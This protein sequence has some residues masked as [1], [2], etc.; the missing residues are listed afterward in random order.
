[1]PQ[2]S[3]RRLGELDCRIITPGGTG[4]GTSDSSVPELVLVL[5]HG[6]G[7]P[8]D[9]L[10]PVTVELFHKFPDLAERVQVVFPAAPLSLDAYGLP[11]GRAWW[12]LDM[13]KLN[14][15][16]QTGEFRDLRREAPPGLAEAHRKFRGVV[17]ELQRE[18]GLPLSRFVLGGFSQGSML[19]T[20]VALHL[21]EKPAG[22]VIWSGTLLHEEEWTVRMPSLSGVPVV[23]SHGTQD[24][25][26]PFE[27]AELLRDRLRSAGAE[28][29]FIEFRGPHTIPPAAIDASGR[30]LQRIRSVQ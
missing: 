16:I 17:E 2:Q 18:S 27:L 25:I 7:A 4:P 30:L 21:D 14:R 11:G 5:C 12:M 15:A 3:T 23:Q 24:M 10:V 1:M 19:V 6:F 28:V 20:D 29:E 8:G 9:D 26:L 22:L 13:E